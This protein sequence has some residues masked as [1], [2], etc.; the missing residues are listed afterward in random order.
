VVKD[1]EGKEVY[2]YTDHVQDDRIPL[3]EDMVAM[4]VVEPITDAKQEAAEVRG[5]RL[6]D[7]DVLHTSV[8]VELDYVERKLN[9]AAKLLK[10]EPEKALDQLV[11]AQT[12]GVTFKVNKEDNP[13][14]AAERALQLAERMVEQARPEAAKENLQLAKNHLV[15]Y[16]GLIAKSE[17]EKVRTLEKDITKLQGQIGKEGA[18]EKIREFWDRVAGWFTSQPGMAEKTTEES[19]PKKENKKEMKE[20]KEK[21]EK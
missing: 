21:K 11:L 14:V 9:Q 4:E 3:F 1:A 17:Q 20:K 2:R 10:E 8:L 19:E 18:A 6:A 13:L 7:A 16:R 12:H 5:L 15:I